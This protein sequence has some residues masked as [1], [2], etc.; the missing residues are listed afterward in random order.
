MTDRL[1]IAYR[2]ALAFVFGAV[3][4]IA[5]AHFVVLFAQVTP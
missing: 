5:L 1:E 4:L 3:G 2:T